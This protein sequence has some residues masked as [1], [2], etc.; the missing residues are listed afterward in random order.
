MILPGR[1]QF[2]PCQL[3]LEQPERLSVKEPSSSARSVLPS[4]KL[5]LLLELQ[6]IIG[7][8]AK[9]YSAIVTAPSPADAWSSRTGG[10]TWA[11]YIPR[12]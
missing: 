8:S 1:A 6:N 3:N 10:Q 11:G 9:N 7:V 2:P 4:Q 12:L 5:R